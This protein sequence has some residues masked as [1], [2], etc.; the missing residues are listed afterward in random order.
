MTACIGQMVGT[1]ER[2]NSQ[3]VS[4]SGRK[5]TVAVIC[6]MTARISSWMV[7]MDLSLGALGETPDP[8]Q[9]SSTVDNLHLA[10]GESSDTRG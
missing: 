1:E 6:L 3:G 9:Q 2:G 5:V 7:L 4:S 8:S 10:A